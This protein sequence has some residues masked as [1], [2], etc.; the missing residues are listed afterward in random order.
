M[1]LLGN[2]QNTFKN[3]ASGSGKGDLLQGLPDMLKGSSGLLGPAAL[4]GLL[5]A[6]VTSKAARG[7]LGGAL[8][9]GGGAML[10]N[11]YKE[12]IGQENASHS[13]NGPQYGQLPSGDRERAERIVRAL[14][15]AA[16]S[17]GHIDQREQAAVM[18][19]VAKLDLGADAEIIVKQALEEPLDPEA[20]VKGVKT[21]DEALEVYTL[22]CAVITTDHFM[23]RSYLDALA[24]AL[25]I[26][27]DV[28]HDLEAKVKTLG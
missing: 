19:E 16:K 26:P 10:W 25:N 5:G 13:Q 3:M 18:G 27:D 9:A 28:K 11:K 17:D 1:N 23:E 14:V 6:L 21:V 15:F 4:G 24:R 22:S 8:L 2:L 20:L 12:R 7:I